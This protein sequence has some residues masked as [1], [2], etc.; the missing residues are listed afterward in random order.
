[1][2]DALNKAGAYKALYV[3]IEAAQAMRGDVSAGLA[4]ICQ[5]IAAHAINDDI[6]PGLTGMAREILG[7][8]HSGTA[9]FDLLSQWARMS[10]QPIVLMLDEVDALVGDTLISLL[11]QIRSGYPQRPKAFPQSIILCGVRD[12][13]DYRIHSKNQEIITGGSAFNIKA[14]SLLMGNFTADEVYQLYQ[15]HTAET[16]QTFD[17]TI[18]PELWE[19]TRGQ[20][21]LVN[22]LGYEMTWKD[23][24]ARDRKVVITNERYLAAR[25]RLIRS[26]QTHLD[27]LTDKLREPRVNQVVEA[28]LAGE[29]N[30]P[31]IR[32]DDLQYV[33]DLGLITTRPSIAISNRIYQEIIPRE[34]TWAWQSTISNQET[35][36]YVLPNGRLDIPALLRAFQQ[37][38]R[39]NSEIWLQGL[40]FKEAGPHLVLQ[41]FLQRIVNGG[42]RINREYALGRKYTDLFLEWPLDEE[43]GFYGEVQKVVLELKIRRNSLDKTISDGVV[44]IANYARRIGTEE[45]YLVIFDRDP[46]VDWET[47]VWEKSGFQDGD[48]RVDVWGC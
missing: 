25:E 46:D 29:D 19:D 34:I 4:V 12:V 45:A 33:E 13:R 40:P 24:E 5:A 48:L 26:R 32:D 47:K 28:I 8:T 30:I 21:W 7:D 18:F 2:A 9:L 16:G 36:W 31:H 20:P 10:D 15:Q 27:Q 35:A 6:E 44:Q 37:F 1:M 41:A 38:F 22:A 39:E 11:R 43:K 42:G 23:R 17:E 14:A 3:N